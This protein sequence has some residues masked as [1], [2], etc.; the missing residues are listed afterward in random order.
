MR[1]ALPAASASL[2]AAEATAKRG[3]VLRVIY[4]ATVSFMIFGI[5]NLLAFFILLLLGLID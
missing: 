3:G 1:V 2:A 5:A 4:S